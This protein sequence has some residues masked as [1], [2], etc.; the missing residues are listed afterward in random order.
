MGR[1]PPAIDRHGRSRFGARWS[2]PYGPMDLERQ[3]ADARAALEEAR[4]QQTATSEILKSMTR[5]AFD[6]EPLLATIIE[7]AGRLSGAEFG[8]VHRFDGEFLHLG[9][10]YRGT[11]EYLAYARR[12]PVRADAG[13]ASGR[14]AL[15]RRTIHI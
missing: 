13:S 7:N 5:S 6:L 4:E 15:E 12:Q 9:A 11:E 2:V 8:A 14:A 10:T 3:L 1:S